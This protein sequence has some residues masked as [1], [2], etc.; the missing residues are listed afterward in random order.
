[1]VR[2]GFRSTKEC[3]YAAEQFMA[4]LVNRKIGVYEF[5]VANS[6]ILVDCVFAGDA[7]KYQ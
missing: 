5:G 2:F 6:D 7:A 3:R 1:M 4:E